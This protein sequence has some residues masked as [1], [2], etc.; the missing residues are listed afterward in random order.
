MPS[1]KRSQ[2]SEPMP[3]AQE[4]WELRSRRETFLERSWTL[5]R[6]E[7]TVWMAE[8]ED[9]LMVRTRKVAAFV[10]GFWTAWGTLMVLDLVMFL[11]DGVDE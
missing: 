4:N 1:V 2:A 3:T 7:R 6:T 5:E 10:R 11:S 9:E 8:G